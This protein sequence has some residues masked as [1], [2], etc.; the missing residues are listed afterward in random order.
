MM[1][2]LENTD[3]I[4]L[5]IKS[6]VLTLFI[7]TPFQSQAQFAWPEDPEQ[8]SIAEEKNVRYTDEL[9]AGNYS[10]AAK[11]LRWL[12]N[13]TPELSKSIYQNGAK[14][15]EALALESAD[16]TVKLA[17]VDTLMQMYDLRIKYFGEEATVMDYKAY[18]AYLYWKGE[19]KK[20]EEL[21]EIF[22]K[23]YE[24]NG[25]DIM[26]VNTVGYMD[27]IRRLKK[28]KPTSL[29]DDQILTI[30]G[31]LFAAVEYQK[32]LGKNLKRLETIQD[33]LDKLL[34]ATVN[35]DC[36]FIDTKLKPKFYQDTTDL[37]LA[38]KIFQLQ[39]SAKCSD[40]PLFLEVAKEIHR[41]E[42][43]YGLAKI[44]AVKSMGNKDWNTAI[45]YLNEGLNLA[46]DDMDKSEMNMDLGVTYKAL[47]EL[48][49]ARTHFLES[50][51]L[52][53]TNK[54]AY[55][56]VGL[57]YFQ[58]FEGCKQGKNPVVD[59]GVFI[60]AYDMFKKAGNTELMETAREQFPTK[61]QV[62]TYT[63][64]IG[65]PLEVDCW[66]NSTVSIATRD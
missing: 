5:A 62:F 58:S 60:A 31:D 35:V 59:R 39:L 44:I 37:K 49:K 66:I 24:L 45:T 15:Y 38:K 21:Y 3:M 26:D 41:Q 30:Y 53:P 4:R 1:Y 16:E 8:R 57:M 10:V 25:Q 52:D 47:G 64:S 63:M 18:S 23:T 55:E 40:T 56:Q 33:N 7:L 36:E 14:I 32:S 54:K 22:A 2:G 11:E 13:N 28:V 51:S 50:A 48:Y 43:T 65:D 61:E 6:L 29:D 20:L 42:P 19:V 12:L 17:Y 27:V 34:A 46:R 9:K